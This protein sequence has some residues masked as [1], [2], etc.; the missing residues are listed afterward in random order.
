MDQE[1]GKVQ[2][3][4]KF[5]AREGPSSNAGE[6]A[7]GAKSITVDRASQIWRSLLDHTGLCPVPRSLHLFPVL[8]LPYVSLSL[9]KPL[10]DSDWI[11]WLPCLCCLLSCIA[12]FEFTL[13]RFKLIVLKFLS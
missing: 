6:A 8:M 2:E 5:E 7:L 4:G 13:F 10:M 9:G 12:G 11:F 3:A 1:L